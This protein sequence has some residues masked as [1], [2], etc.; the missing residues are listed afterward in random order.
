MSNSSSDNLDP[1]AG[2]TTTPS[3][4]QA[5]S[6]LRVAAGEKA[7]EMIHNAESK[8]GKLRGLIARAADFYGPYATNISVPYLLVIKRL[9]AGKRLW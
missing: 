1:E 6:D 3:V 9:A 8:A 2:F 7:K 5:A 4:S